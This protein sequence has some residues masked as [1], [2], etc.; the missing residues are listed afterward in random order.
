MTHTIIDLTSESNPTRRIRERD[1]GDVDALVLHQMSF[2]R[3]PGARRY[4]NT[5]AH[6]ICLT[7]GTVAQLHRPEDYLH[8]SSALNNRSVA[9]EFAGNMPS[10]RGRYYRPGKFGR[11]RVT[12]SQVSAGRWL[13]LHLRGT[14]GISYVFAHR[15]GT[16]GHTNCCGPDVWFNVGEWALGQGLSDGGSGFRVGQGLPI[17]NAWRHHNYVVF[18]EEEVAGHD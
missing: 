12:M 15:Q 10:E 8:A 3:G 4:L 6:Y 16:N 5:N 17:P 1:V 11:D 18:T 7:D 14:L 13:I 9:V 2:D